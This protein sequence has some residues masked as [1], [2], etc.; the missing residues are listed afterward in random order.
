MIKIEWSL[1]TY[2]H[3]AETQEF[4][5]NNEKIKDDKVFDKLKFSQSIV[6]SVKNVGFFRFRITKG[7][8]IRYYANFF[9]INNSL[10][11][12]NKFLLTVHGTVNVLSPKTSTN[13]KKSSHTYID[14][15]HGSYS[16]I[17]GS[18]DNKKDVI[19]AAN[20]ICSGFFK[21]LISGEDNLSFCQESRKILVERKNEPYFTGRTPGRTQP[22]RRV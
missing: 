18:Y 5:A 17:V 19:N 13:T 22:T 7:C 15:N 21:S 14:D 12:K 1:V 8:D 10:H 11:F 6:G 2:E 16:A 9:N 4:R 20:E 3:V